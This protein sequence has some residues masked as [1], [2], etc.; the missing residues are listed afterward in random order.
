MVRFE[1]EGKVLGKPRPRVNRNGRVWT[2]KKFKDYEDAISRAYRE[3]G[4]SLQEGTVKV[5][6]ETFRELP[7]SRPKRV[8][9]E[10]DIFKPDVDNVAK[11]VLDALNGTAYEDDSKVTEL[12]VKKNPR[13]RRDGEVLEV[14][15][16]STSEVDGIV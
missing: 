16:E 14:K 9:S 4:G 3:A 15:V 6:I 7:K 8:S 10:E 11:I 2:P 5:E 12:R 1:V 13:T